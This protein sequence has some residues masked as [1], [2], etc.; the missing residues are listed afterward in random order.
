LGE[1]GESVDPSALLPHA[2]T[3]AKM[4]PMKAP[5]KRPIVKRIIGSS[6]LHS[7]AWTQADFSFWAIYMDKISSKAIVETPFKSTAM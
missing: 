5:I 3:A 2:I 4:K 7:V 1:G 6:F